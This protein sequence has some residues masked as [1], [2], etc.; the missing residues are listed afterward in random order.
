MTSLLLALAC[1]KDPEETTDPTEPTVDTHT[2]PTPPTLPPEPLGVTIHRTTHGVAH[3]TADDLHGIGFGTG[4]AYTEDNRCLL[5]Q[6]LAEV[7]GELSAQLGAEASIEIPVHA[8]VVRAIDSDRFY[9]GWY[10]RDAIVAAFDAGP[11]EVRELAQGYADG[12]NRYVADHPELAPC[13][14]GLVEPVAIDSVYAMWV[15]TAGVASGELLEAFIATEAPSSAARVGAAPAE[16]TG[17][18]LFGRGFGSNA[19]AIGRDGTQDGTSVHLYNPHFPWSG[20]HRV[21]QVHV[22]IPGELDVLG[23]ALGGFPLPIVG[24]D[25]DKVWGLTFSTAARFTVSELPLVAGD[26]RSYTVDGVTHA[27]TEEVFEIA[28]AGED[29]PRTVSFFR[30]EHGPLLDAPEYLMGWTASK[31]YAVHDVNADNTQLVEQLLGIA[32]AT[33]VSEIRDSLSSVRGIP[34]SYTLAADAGGDVLFGDLSRV[35]GVT[36]EQIETCATPVSGLLRAFGIFVLDGGTSSCAWTDPLAAEELPWAIR[37][38]YLANSN[39]TYELP[40]LAEP[41]V[42]STVAL[43]EPGVPLALR[44]ALGLRMIESRIAGD[45]GLG[46][47]GFTADLALQSYTSRRNLAG[48]LLADAIAEDCLA[49]PTGTAGGAD[50]DLTAVCE[51]LA[52]WDQTAR[53]DSAGAVV[54]AGMWAQLVASGKTDQVFDIPA[55]LADPMGTPSG[56]ATGAGIRSTVNNALAVVAVELQEAGIEPTA[57]WGDTHAVEGPTGRIGLPGGSSAEGIFDALDST[58]GWTDMLAGAAPEDL[59]GASYL[60]VV[61]LGATGASARGLLTYSQATEPTSPWYLD[62]LEAHA[63]DAWF[64]LPFHPDEIAA[65]PALTTLEL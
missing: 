7:D 33:S 35:P 41:L 2:T 10:D 56:Y 32:R 16:V 36:T 58:Y 20:I 17:P 15:A 54:F 22:T 24:F 53:I 18:P 23:G 46:P 29:E 5:A 30:S 8:M 6:R 45:D 47:A 42:G 9:R 31:A 48:E 28:V 59:Y 65:D 21:W 51:A 64:D 61:T 11:A 14:V 55:S 37:S 62:Q 63:A 40:N 50:V 4:Y 49:D 43:G 60:H 39:N 3:V 13:P 52:A 26:P 27:I 1:E 12:I 38:D 44:P 25:D 57:P 19:W 34:W